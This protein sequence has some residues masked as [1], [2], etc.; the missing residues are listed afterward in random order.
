[1]NQVNLPDSSRHRRLVVLGL[2]LLALM[3]G[4]WQLQRGWSGLASMAQ[5]AAQLAV[6]AG[7]M[8]TIAAVTPNRIVRFTGDPQAYGA[9]LAASMMHDGLG[10]LQ[11]EV[12]TDRVRVGLALATIL[13]GAV[14]LLAGATGLTAASW[15]AR[16]SRQSRD[17]LEAAFS[18]IRALL[19]LL[20]GSLVGGLAV[21]CSAAVVFEL[22]GWLF[23]T[24]DGRTE[25]RILTPGFMLAG[26]VLWLGWLTVRELRRSLAAF[27]PSPMPLLGRE[28]TAD[29]APGLW[30]FLAERAAEQGAAT[31]DHVAVGLVDG[32]FVTSADVALKPGSALLR[33]RTLHIPL[34][35]LAMLDAGETAAIIGHEL[36]HF[37]TDTGYSM[38]FLPIYTGIE[39]NLKALRSVRGQS[40]LAWTQGPAITLGTHMMAVFDGAV[41]HW[42]RLRE[43]EADRA[44][45]Q[46]SGAEAAA[47]ALV[48]TALLQPVI[49]AV[50]SEAWQ[51]TGGAS[52]DLVGTI[53]ARAEAD[54]LGDPAIALQERQ[55]HPTDSHPP[56]SQ[57]LEALGLAVTAPLLAQA[58]RPVQAAATVFARGLFRDWAGLCAA[59]CADA[60]GVAASN[61]AERTARLREAADQ[62]T[63]AI[64][65]VLNDWRKAAVVWGIA[66]AVFLGAGLFLAYALVFLT[67]NDPSQIP[68]LWL[69]VAALLAVGA[70]C[71]LRGILLWRGRNTPLITLS[72]DGFLCRGLDRM[73]PWIGVERVS[74][75]RQRSTH[76]F[77]HLTE[78][79]KLPKRVSGW[80]VLVSAR[81]R[82]VT[83]LGIRPRGLS[84][85]GLV[86]LIQ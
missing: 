79:T 13:G 44:G 18:R 77:I 51:E 68:V 34:P 2:P 54:G 83:M 57:R 6:Q 22:A 86:E 4:A 63:E 60:I 50:L 41:K 56:S 27:T 52:A 55:P 58:S 21:A 62:V 64:V 65:E 47:R 72:T 81:R 61:R 20:L 11:W 10:L 71:V 17:A 23:G 35:M 26:A 67:V 53:I 16:R 32:F 42:S 59:V 3:L 45:A 40:T 80:G 15:A 28:V 8:D 74:V 70:A 33:G 5:E 25:I 85:D 14:S 48:R 7:Q 84:P 19:P 76:V 73:V 36:A 38:R 29:E 69:V 9:Q 24:S 31:P 46:H 39:R 1:M 12:L 82:V 30:R 49:G 78:T 37:A 43:I 66:A 75:T